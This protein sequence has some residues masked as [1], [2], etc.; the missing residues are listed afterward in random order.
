MRLELLNIDTG[1]KGKAT[2]GNSGARK[3]VKGLN[4]I[5]GLRSRH[6]LGATGQQRVVTSGRKRCR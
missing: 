4:F 1:E 2:R 5:S 3:R 6:E